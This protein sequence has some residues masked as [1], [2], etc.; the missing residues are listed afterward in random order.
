MEN[1]NN[2][3]EVNKRMKK[4]R[5]QMLR[6]MYKYSQRSLSF[7]SEVF[8]KADKLRTTYEDL[9]RQRNQEI[10]QAYAYPIVR[11]KTAPRKS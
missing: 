10:K 4:V 5:R 7:D 2:I 6:V 11:P 3:S 8:I 1:L 9:V